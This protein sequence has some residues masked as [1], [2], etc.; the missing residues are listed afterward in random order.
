MDQAIQHADATPI[1]ELE[2]S[3]DALEDSD[4]WLE[5]SPDE[6]D[7]MLL[8]ASGKGQ[9]EEAAEGE[10]AKMDLGAEHGQALQD[11]AK[12]VEQFVGGQGDI[13]GA[14]FAE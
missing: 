2:V 6:L 4:S 1:L 3:A 10:T 7:G 9:N 8:R 5:V 14:K 13:E 11:L 12:K